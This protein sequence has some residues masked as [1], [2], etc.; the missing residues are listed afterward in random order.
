MYL[1]LILDGSKLSNL[2]VDSD[3]VCENE[4]N[5]KIE[6]FRFSKI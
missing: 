5:R 1:F 4:K 3:F 6:H 2:R